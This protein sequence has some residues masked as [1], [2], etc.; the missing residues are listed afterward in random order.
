MLESR[1]IICDDSHHRNVPIGNYLSQ[2]FG[3]L[4]L[5]ELDT[6][7][8]QEL[9]A[10]AYI[11]F[12]DDYLIFS[13][14][15]NFLKY[16]DKVI[17]D[18][19]ESYLGL[20][21]SKHE[22]FQ[23]KQGVDFLGYRHFPDDYILVR[24]STAKRIKKRLK[25][26]DK[27]VSRGKISV[28]KARAQWASA[29]GWI[30]HANAHNFSIYLKMEEI[31]KFL[32][33]KENEIMK[34]VPKFLNTR[35]DYD[36]MQ[37]NFPKEVWQPFFQALLDTRNDWFFVKVLAENEEGII[38]DT[39]KVEVNEETRIKTQFEYR[40]NNSCKLRQLGYTVD[41]VERMIRKG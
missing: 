33:E 12:C 8:K 40:F 31:D 20:K 27:R 35:D 11:R 26:I 9:K 29:K 39:H 30:G 5:N 24:K 6:L 28:E 41:E 36:Y 25:N 16:C 1:G 34:G 23:T 22:I 2:W 13:D 37:L 4:Y 14:D 3:N 38:D 32:E 17:V 15:I 18:F 21:L 19:T 7:V 10:V